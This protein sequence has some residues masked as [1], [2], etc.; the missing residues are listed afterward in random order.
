MG[1]PDF[2]ANG[3]IFASLTTAEDWGVV[4]IT[5]EEQKELNR[6][7]SRCVRSGGG[8]LGPSGL[9]EGLAGRGEPGRRARRTD[10][11]LG[12]H[13][14][15]AA[16]A[17]VAQQETLTRFE[18]KMR[19]AARRRAW[20]SRHT[21]SR[22]ADDM[23]A[24]TATTTTT[25]PRWSAVLTRDRAA[26]GEFFYSVAT[27]G[28]YCRPSCAAR[29][30]NPR[31]VRFHRTA[32]DA[33]RA[34]FRPCKRCRPDAASL[35]DRRAALIAEA[36]R[37]IETAEAA[38]AL[39]TLARRAGLSPASLPS[40]LQVGDR[41]DA[42]GLCR[43]ASPHPRPRRAQQAPDRHRSHLRGR[44]QLRQPLLRVRIRSCWA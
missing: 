7:R 12:T 1:H 11:R 35:D 26:D 29:L 42:E 16:A 27:T 37:T 20:D 36:C 4:M 5:P 17:E 21:T 41:R 14:R 15:A 19:S 10:P 40:H 9:Y 25:D 28:V 34:G 22:K 33:E 13:C 39:R 30:P 23:H 44:L 32:A 24:S 3:R 18:S 8:G 43:R 2:R 6:L 38:P 31:N